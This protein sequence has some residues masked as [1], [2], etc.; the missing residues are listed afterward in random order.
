PR[1]QYAV[2][3]TGQLPVQ[4]GVFQPT[5]DSRVSLDG[6]R[7]S[8]SLGIQEELGSGGNTQTRTD[9]PPLAKA[10]APALWGPESVA[11]G[12]SCQE[13]PGSA[14]E[15]AEVDPTSVRSGSQPRRQVQGLIDQGCIR[16]DVLAHITQN[17]RL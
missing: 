17:R 1:E 3:G 5:H 7:P 16:S 15:I 13:T 8:P 6:D 2:G 12:S 14:S 10:S 4:V 11:N 9:S